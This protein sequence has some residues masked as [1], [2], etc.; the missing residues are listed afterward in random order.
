MTKDAL[1]LFLSHQT[2]TEGNEIWC[3]SP[4]QISLCFLIKKKSRVIEINLLPL[5]HN[6]K[7]RINDGGSVVKYQVGCSNEQQNLDFPLHDRHALSEF[8]LIKDELA[9]GRVL[10]II[11]PLYWL[12]SLG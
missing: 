6:K 4:Y 12:P 8:P 9:C 1:D 2:E 3:P 5:N 10:K 11:L 7:L